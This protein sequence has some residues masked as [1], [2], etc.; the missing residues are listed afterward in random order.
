MATTQS[1]SPLFSPQTIRRS[2][3]QKPRRIDIED[4]RA[5]LAAEAQMG[6]SVRRTKKAV[7]R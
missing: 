6:R 3:A 7:Q 2:R 5:L 4:Y 1:I